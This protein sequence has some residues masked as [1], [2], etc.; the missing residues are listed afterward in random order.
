[1]HTL[2]ES[3][4][5]TGVVAVAVAVNLHVANTVVDSAAHLKEVGE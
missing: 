2:G 5:S 1:V 3:R 4:D